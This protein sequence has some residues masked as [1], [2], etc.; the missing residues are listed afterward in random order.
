[1]VSFRCKAALST[2]KFGLLLFLLAKV[3]LDSKYCCKEAIER[4]GRHEDL[5]IQLTKKLC[6]YSVHTHSAVVSIHNL[7]PR[8]SYRCGK[9]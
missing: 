6:V 8:A 4:N 1:M 7:V 5:H 3:F 2:A 9:I